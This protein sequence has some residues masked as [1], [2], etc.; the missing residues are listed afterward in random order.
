MGQRK[1]TLFNKFKNKPRKIIDCTKPSSNM[2]FMHG[3][4]LSDAIKPRCFEC[5]KDNIPP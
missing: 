4:F 5:T 1:T 2:H 3:I